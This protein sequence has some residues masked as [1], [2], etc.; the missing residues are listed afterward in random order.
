M[1]LFQLAERPCG[2]L[3]AVANR[4]VR[5]SV[6]MS[7]CRRGTPSRVAVAPFGSGTLNVS[8]PL[9]PTRAG[10]ARFRRDRAGEVEVITAYS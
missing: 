3:H 10:S 8:K 9:L 4:V 5:Q 6:L 7:A 1:R 2:P